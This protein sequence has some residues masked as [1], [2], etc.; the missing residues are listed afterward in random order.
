M[1]EANQAMA[2][3]TPSGGTH[4]T[5]SSPSK[6]GLDLLSP[7]WRFFAAPQVLVTLLGLVAL[8]LLL[9]TLIPQIPPEAMDDPETWLAM[10]SGSWSRISGFVQTLGFHDLLHS[11]GFRLLLALAGLTLFVWLADSAALAWRA[12]G[13]NPRQRPSWSPE[14]FGYWG[15]NAL[16][17]SADSPGILNS[18]ESQTWESLVEQG[19]RVSRVSDQPLPNLVAHKRAPAL[20]AFPVFHGALLAALAGLTVGAIWGW[21]T[22]DWQLLPGDNQAVGHGTPY[23]LRLDA[24]DLQLDE[25]G[26]LLDYRSHITWLEDGAE[27]GKGVAIS[28]RPLMFRGLT[29]RQPGYAPVVKL[30]GRDSA[31]RP[32]ALQLG[33]EEPDSSAD[34]T[35]T[36]PTPS[37]QQLI[38]VDDDEQFVVL[39]FQ[40]L[41]AEGK[42]SLHLDLLGEDGTERQPL[43]ILH[44]SGSVEIGDMRL[45]LELA[46]R[47]ILRVERRPG[48][49]LVVGGAALAVLALAVAWLASPQLVWIALGDREEGGTRVHVMALPPERGSRWPRRLTSYLQRAFDNGD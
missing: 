22:Q 9:G 11:P 44:E 34:L 3:E 7:V 1:R 47:P 2:E 32:V 19:F 33:G 25:T 6:Q 24:F 31:G 46:Y 5:T 39:S 30:R 18:T 12:T 43:T 10:Q 20:W 49:S 23:V 41:S 40:P 13:W 35:V 4:S 29:V 21:R 42:P 16:E 14:A 27:I 8:T 36:F 48:P 15:R 26:R 37:T 38:L 45:E 28:H 17:L